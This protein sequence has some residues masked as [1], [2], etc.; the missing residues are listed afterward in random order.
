MQL[1]R[2]DGLDFRYREAGAGVPFFFQH[3]LGGDV[4]QPFGLLTP[5]PGVRLLAV[6]CRAHGQTRPIGDPDKISLAAFADDLAALMDHLALE[7]AVVGGI[8]MGAAVALNFALRYPDRVLG[9]VISRP[10]WLAGPMPQNAEIYATIARLIRRHG[11]SAGLELFVQTDAYQATFRE[12][13][14][15]ARSLLGQFTHPRAAE[16]VVRLERIPQDSPCRDLA[17]LQSLSMPT[18][19]MANRQDPIHPFEF[20]TILAKAIPGA[21]LREL[22]PK[23]QSTD[24]HRADVQAAVEEFLARRD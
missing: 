10:A 14:D 2:H 21:Q 4:E 19:V 18:L 13:P 17:E 5:P 15:A 6:D 8:S 20:G 11:P 12:S 9:L 22:T 7:R 16:A 24:R 3:G 23:S 1:W